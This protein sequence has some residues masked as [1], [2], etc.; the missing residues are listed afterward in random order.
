MERW[1]EMRAQS[2][3]RNRVAFLWATGILAV[4]FGAL[5]LDIALDRGAPDAKNFFALS[6]KDA[7]E[8]LRVAAPIAIASAIGHGLIRRFWTRS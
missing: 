1:A 8:F 5:A 7:S 3:L 4:V 2:K 6:P